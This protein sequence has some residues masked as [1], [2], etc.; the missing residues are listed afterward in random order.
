MDNGEIIKDPLNRYLHKR[1]EKFREKIEDFT[2]ID[3]SIHDFLL[4]LMLYGKE[5]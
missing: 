5:V 4:M 1:R 2:F 3:R